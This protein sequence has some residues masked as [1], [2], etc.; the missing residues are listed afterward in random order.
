MTETSGPIIKVS[1]L[2]QVGIAVRDLEDSMRHYESIF[3]IAS[4]QVMTVDS[5]IISEM[6]YHG[7]PA[8][9]VFRVALVTVGQMELELLQPAAGE[10][11]YSDFLKEHGEG[12]HHLGHVKVDNL[13]EAVQRL[14]KNG[15]AYLQGGRYQ[16]GGYAYIDMVKPLGYIIELVQ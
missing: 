14:Q 11:I 12:L 1:E 3:G 15:F 8:E 6:T 9:Y 16:G 13:D 10:N 2:R 7:K 4:W 5:S